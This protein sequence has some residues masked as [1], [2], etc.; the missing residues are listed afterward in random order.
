MLREQGFLRWSEGHAKRSV[1]ATGCWL[2]ESFPNHGWWRRGSEESCILLAMV[3]RWLCVVLTILGVLLHA[4]PAFAQSK[5]DALIKQLI[6]SDDFRIRTQAALALGASADSAAVAPLCSALKKDANASVRTASAAAL[7]KLKKAAGGPC[8]ADAKQK[9]REPTVLAQIDRAM[10]DLGETP[11]PGPDAKF[12]ISVQ[13]TNK[14]TRTNEEIESLVR[15]AAVTSLLGTKAI[16]VAP[17]SESAAQARAILKAKNL[18]G[19]VMLVTVDAP[20]YSGGKLSVSVGVSLWTYPEQSLK[21][22]GGRKT[23]TQE[24]TPTK[25]VASETELLKLVVQSAAEGFSREVTKL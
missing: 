18:R 9:E 5:L 1:Y 8:L 13:V 12:Y 4:A 24:N 3:A 10:A 20:N 14:T 19:F 25:D 6:S 23:A 17:R 21:G 2:L 11:P 7:G 22:T 15:S 16:A